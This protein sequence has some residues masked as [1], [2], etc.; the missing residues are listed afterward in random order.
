VVPRLPPLPLKA[1]SAPAHTLTAEHIISAFGTDVDNGLTEDAARQALEKYG[2]NKL[3]EIPPPSFWSILVRNTLNAMTL[4]LIAA[5]AVSFGTQDF[6]S[7]GVIAALVVINVGVGTINE[8][9]A[10]KT[11]AALEA[12]GAPTANVLRRKA[13]GSPGEIQTIK[14]DMVVPGMATLG[15]NARLANR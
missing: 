9:Q 14:T 3:K 1:L 11:V 13:A 2:P 12:I 6:I 7:G 4:V 8:Y 10:E 15:R 5:M